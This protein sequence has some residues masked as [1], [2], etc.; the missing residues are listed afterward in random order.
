MTDFIDGVE[1]DLVDAATRRAHQRRSALTRFRRRAPRRGLAIAI[2]ALLAAGSAT[3][4]VVTLTAAEPSRPLAGAVDDAK[5]SVRSYAITLLPSLQTGQA[6]WCTILRLS[7]GGE[8]TSG[9]MGC[10][11]AR[12]AGGNMIAAG[13]AFGPRQN[14]E[15]VVATS[16]TRA[17]RFSDGQLV[18]TRSDPTLPYRWRYAVAITAGQPQPSVT[19]PATA[20]IPRTGRGANTSRAQATPRP[21]TPPSR[22]PMS[23]PVLL[24]AH[25]REL[26]ST[27]RAD[28]HARGARTRRVTQTQPAERCIIG[29]ARGY[30]ISTAR[31]ALGE[32][33]VAPRL[34]GRAFFTCARTIFR[35]PRSRTTLNAMILLDARHPQHRAAALPPTPALSG[36]QLGTGWLAIY[37]GNAEQ[38]NALLRR[39]QPRL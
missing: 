11:P 36:R 34:Q 2:V 27:T 3:A 19:P 20:T 18:A 1:R 16:N 25:G 13:G 24:D 29:T 26:A 12:A 31:V 39:L 7:S 9:G 23:A 22:P 6:G 32:A 35:N 37:G 30:R 15:Y 4:A 28:N 21:N 33:R 10:G 5:P 8:P 38:R 17:V 14:I